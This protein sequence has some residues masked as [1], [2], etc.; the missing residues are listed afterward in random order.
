M[1]A[2]SVT[3]TTSG[4]P[5]AVISMGTPARTCVSSTETATSGG[6]ESAVTT[7]CSRTPE[8]I[9]LAGIA[10]AP[11]GCVTGYDGSDCAAATDEPS[12]LAP[13]PHDNTPTATATASTVTPAQIRV[14]RR[15]F[16]FSR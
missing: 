7:G 3:M 10:I 12:D 2:E 13:Q 1:Q 9:A 5:S 11:A 6:S 15:A 4:E 16:A 8:L 14:T